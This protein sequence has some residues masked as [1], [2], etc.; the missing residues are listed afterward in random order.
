MRPHAAT[1]KAFS[2]G[3]AL[4]YRVDGDAAKPPLL[5]SN[6]LG[7]TMAMWAEQLGALA[8]GFRIIRYDTR[9]HGGSQA[10]GGDYTIDQLGRD[11]LAVLDAAGVK[12][13]HVC[14]LSLGGLTAMW[15][16]VHASARI[17]TV[18]LASTAARIGSVEMWNE[19]IEQ[20]REVGTSSIADR[21]MAR[22]FT[23]GF[24]SARPEVVGIF[25]TM[26]AS[27]SGSG[28]AGCCAALREADLGES[29]GGITRPA[30]VI[31]GA[32]DP[33]TPPADGRAVHARIPAAEF[34]LLDGSHLVNVEQPGAFNTAL[35]QFLTKRSAVSN[36]VS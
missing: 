27:C 6:S 22:W 14:G 7:T 5:L 25:R 26:F 12:R 23:E 10:P 36:E 34:V 16:A 28:Y 21:V 17:E 30:L 19:R 9:G 4:A 32:S 8:S 11:A 18:V 13:A 20:V 24:R 15:L 3:C 33:A 35:M 29:L 2:D 1:G 31:S